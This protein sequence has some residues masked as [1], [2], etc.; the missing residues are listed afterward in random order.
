MNKTVFKICEVRLITVHKYCA[1]YTVG[2]IRAC[3]HSDSC[4]FMSHFLFLLFCLICIY[5]VS[6]PFP[7]SPLSINQTPYCGTIKKKKATVLLKPHSDRL[8]SSFERASL[9][10]SISLQSD[11]NCWRWASLERT[12]GGDRL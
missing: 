11:L 7:P 5:P 9:S 2:L 4:F 1:L 12:L 3:T 6:P 10:D 8:G